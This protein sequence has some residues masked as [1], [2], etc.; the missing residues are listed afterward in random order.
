MLWS[1]YVGT[2]HRTKINV[3][4]QFRLSD[5]LRLEFDLLSD[6]LCLEFDRQAD[7]SRLD[8]EITKKLIEEFDLHVANLEANVRRFLFCARVNAEGSVLVSGGGLRRGGLVRWTKN[9]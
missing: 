6:E 9:V 7:K 8:S 4:L 3:T 1:W 2:S 5:E